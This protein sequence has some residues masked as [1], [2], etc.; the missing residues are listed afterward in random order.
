MPRADTCNEYWCQFSLFV[1]CTGGGGVRWSRLNPGQ[2]V[3][4]LSE[5]KPGYVLGRPHQKNPK[6]C[7]LAHNA[8]IHPPAPCLDQ[9][10]N[11]FGGGV[12]RCVFACPPFWTRPPGGHS[13]QTHAASPPAA[14]RPRRRVSEGV[15]F[16]FR[17]PRFLDTA[18]PLDKR[19]KFT[20]SRYHAG[21]TR[22][23]VFK[24]PT[25]STQSFP[26]PPSKI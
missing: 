19:V 23:R 12:G 25:F 2:I 16:C 17:L 4:C 1:T 6:P 5:Y 8:G 22:W 14:D 10:A 26:P 3:D 24:C 9:Q 13:S 20:R 18:F 21:R 11:I 7:S 15:Q